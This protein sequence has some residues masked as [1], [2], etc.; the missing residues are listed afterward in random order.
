MASTNSNEWTR[1][2]LLAPPSSGQTSSEVGEPLKSLFA[3]RDWFAIQLSDPYQAMAEL[4]LRERAQAARA[5]WGLKR[6]EQLALAI[7]QPYVWQDQV[8]NEL[9][10]SVRQYLPSVTIWRI[11]HDEITPWNISDR[12]GNPVESAATN[13]FHTPVAP[14]KILPQESLAAPPA[15]PPAAS[16]SPTS[17][18]ISR[19]E[20]HMLLEADEK[21]G[22][23]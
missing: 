15:A 16:H 4:C 19:E 6:L 7:H 8:I 3:A 21:E 9:V 5:G 18:R 1:V 10:D 13:T 14:G 23:L 2:V 17:S 12:T 20:I 22:L 11:D